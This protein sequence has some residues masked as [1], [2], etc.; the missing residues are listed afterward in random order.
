MYKYASGYI[1]AFNIV[2]NLNK[3]G[4]LDKYVDFLSSG[5]SM[6]VSMLLKKIDIDLYDRDVI[7]DS[8]ILLEDYINEL[9]LLLSKENW[10]GFDYKK[11]SFW[12]SSVY[13]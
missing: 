3:K 10:Y 7:S 9:E 8:F 4:Y 2:R 6:D 5:C 1:L 12:F 13:I 11:K